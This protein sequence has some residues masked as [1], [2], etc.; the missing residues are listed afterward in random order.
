MLRLF[1][2]RGL[3]QIVSYTRCVFVG[4]FFFNHFTF[5][6]AFILLFIAASIITVFYLARKKECPISSKQIQTTM[7]EMSQTNNVHLNDDLDALV[8]SFCFSIKYSKM[9]CFALLFRLH[10]QETFVF[11]LLPCSLANT[12][13]Y[14][15]LY[16]QFW[17][18]TLRIINK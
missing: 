8:G 16:A 6:V 9:F 2:L 3:C 18:V 10:F 4:Y 12:K 7:K 13:Y 17:T 11:D 1:F 5:V 14:L 15:Y